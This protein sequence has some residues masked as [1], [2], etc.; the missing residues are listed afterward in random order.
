[1]TPFILFVQRSTSPLERQ[2][3]RATLIL[4]LTPNRAKQMQTKT[5][6][7][8]LFYALKP[9]DVQ[10]QT[11]SPLRLQIHSKIPPFPLEESALLCLTARS[12]YLKFRLLQSP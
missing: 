1:M 11:G 7:A 9:S 6:L 12:S 4:M 10:P 3:P 8:C 5:T 2:H